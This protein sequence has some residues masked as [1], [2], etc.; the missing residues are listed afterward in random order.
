MAKGKTFADK[1]MKGQLLKK[2]VCDQCNTELQYFKVIRPETS[3]KG[4]IRFEDRMVKVCKC[5]ESEV[6]AS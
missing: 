6:F 3:S 2:A 5:N 4:S 1:A